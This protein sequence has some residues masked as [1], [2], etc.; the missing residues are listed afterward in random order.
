MIF[1][2]FIDV[3]F[4]VENSLYLVCLL[5]YLLIFELIGIHAFWIKGAN[6]RNI[7]CGSI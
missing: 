5:V 4:Y 3:C 1:E 2:M 7:F 6:W